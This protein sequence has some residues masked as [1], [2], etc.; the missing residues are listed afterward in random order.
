MYRRQSNTWALTASGSTWKRAAGL[1]AAVIALTGCH[2]AGGPWLGVNTYL[3]HGEYGGLWPSAKPS[4]VDRELYFRLVGEL[5]V[6][7]VRDLFCSWYRAEPREGQPYDFAV[8][9]DIARR[10]GEAGVDLLGV[11]WVIPSWAAEGESAADWSL[12][13]PRRDKAEAFARFVTA[14]VK[15]YGSAGLFAA[16]G[17]R[18]PVRCY[19]FMNEMEGVPVAEYA[20]WLKLFYQTVKTADPGAIVVLGGLTSPGHRMIERPEGDYHKYFDRLMA[21]PEL[22]GRQYPY[23]DAVSFHLYPASY[24]GRE[25]FADA[26]LYLRQV[27]ELHRV[28]RP[29]WLTAFGADS[30]GNLPNELDVQAREVVKMAVQA[31]SLG[32]ERAYL[33]GLWDYRQPG[34]PDITRNF[35][36]VREAPSGQSPEKK[37]AFDAVR[38]LA[39]LAGHAE[40]SQTGPG[41]FAIRTGGVTSYVAWREEGGDGGI[42]SDRLADAWWQVTSLDGRKTVLHGSAIRLTKAP[43]FLTPTRSP[44][45]LQ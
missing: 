12:G 8:T 45:I 10:A 5:R 16:S 20:Y 34:R 42:R 17:W 33:N 44:F 41:F 22:A 18:R 27:L 39:S 1:C 43:I 25:P 28:N 32:V 6:T 11:C 38:E 37:P 14:F 15:R 31:R 2:A 24:P 21:C 40:I 13:V 26:V 9:D 3:G 7:H 19:E 4:P 36:L 29:L 35:G 23:F 30:R